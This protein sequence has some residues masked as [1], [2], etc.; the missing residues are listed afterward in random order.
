MR[1][2]RLAPLAS[3]AAAA[4]V[5]GAP[6]AAWGASGATVQSGWWN[7]AAVGALAAPT[8]TPSDQ[9]QVSN[10]FSGPLAFAAVRVTAPSGTPADWVVTLTLTVPSGATVGTPAV[11]ACPTVGRWKPGA[12]QKPSSAP[13]YSC[14]SGHQADGAP[15]NGVEKWTVPL[16]W[17]SGGTVSVALVP[18]PGTTSPFSVAYTAPTPASVTFGPQPAAAAPV[19]S[20]PSNSPY[21]PSGPGSGSGSGPGS[22]TGPGS[23]QGSPAATGQPVSAPGASGAP[24]PAGAFT[25]GATGPTGSPAAAGAPPS[26]GSVPS[27]ASA[28]GPGAA[29]GPQT[30]RNPAGGVTGGA[31]GA[32]LAAAPGG[33]TGAGA[34]GGRAGRLMAFC[35]LVVTGLV[36]FFLSA[37]PDRAPRL[38]GPLTSRVRALTGAVPAAEPA[39][40]AAGGP[41][42]GVGR[43][44]RERNAPPRRL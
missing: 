24:A 37:Q 9:L 2:S 29:T 20:A 28:G 41:V 5:A 10:G 4:A 17:G 26:F 21:P 19:P 13:G 33:G 39:P 43:F 1:A 12:D 36:L 40:A 25:A 27:G 32:P 30:A 42:R 44:A 18:T 23:G 7:E 3:L 34:G 8:T 15:G 22:G 14:R 35:L 31:V 11:S 6:A 38:L 16:S